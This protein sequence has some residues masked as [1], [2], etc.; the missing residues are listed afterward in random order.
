MKTSTI[1]NR[2]ANGQ[3]ASTRPYQ[4]RM[5]RATLFLAVPLLALAFAFQG[6]GSSSKVTSS[7]Q[8]RDATRKSIKKVLVLGLF[9]DKDRVLRLKTEQE[10]A[11]N[12]Q[13]LGYQAV[14]AAEEYG[15]KAFQNMKE[16]QAL[17]R[18]RDIN[19][20][21]VITVT[22]L[23]KNKEQ[24]YVP[25]NVSYAPY[26]VMRRGFWGYYS[27]YYPRVYDPGYYQ[28]STS[29]FFETSLYNMD[30]KLLYSAQ[31]ETFD[32]SSMSSLA[33][34]YAKEIVKDM[35]KKNIF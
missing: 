9:T 31:S 18:L 33:D 21:G 4:G 20:D 12:L 32:P 5:K 23:N 1:K 15:P 26:P 17:K 35:R 30:N 28:T 25:G 11:D 7:W 22:L 24:Y 13:A 6:C 27:Y 14:T 16:D 29:Y 3:P 10:L 34:E 2:Q 19:V 8:D